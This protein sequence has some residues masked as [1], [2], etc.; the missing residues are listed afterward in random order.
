MCVHAG[1]KLR[2]GA[3][4]VRERKEITKNEKMLKIAKPPTLLPKPTRSATTCD[5][6]HAPDAPVSTPPPVP[7]TTPSRK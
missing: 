5:E 3:V 7:R 1:A 4:R 2:V 6:L